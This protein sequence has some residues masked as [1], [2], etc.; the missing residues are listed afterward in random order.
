MKKDINDILKSVTPETPIEEVAAYCD[1]VEDFNLIISKLPHTESK[2][3]TLSDE[4]KKAALSLL[5]QSKLNAA[6]ITTSFIQRNMPVTY[7]Q[8]TALVDW[9]KLTLQS[10]KL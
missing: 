3:V 10:G 8:A 1:T 2:P 7:P 5:T 4:L 6:D 9:L